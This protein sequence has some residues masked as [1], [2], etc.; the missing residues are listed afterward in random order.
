LKKELGD[1]LVSSCLITMI[2]PSED[3]SSDANPPSSSFVAGLEYAPGASVN[4]IAASNHSHWQTYTPSSE[5]PLQGDYDPEPLPPAYDRIPDIYLQHVQAD[6]RITNDDP[7]MRIFRRNVVNTSGQ[8]GAHPNTQ[9]AHEPLV[10]PSAYARPPNV[11]EMIG[12]ATSSAPLD[13]MIP[14]VHSN[15]YPPY[16][17][18]NSFSGPPLPTPSRGLL[19]SA[20]G[21]NSPGKN[22][23]PPMPPSF[24]R[25]PPPNLICTTFPPMCL[26]ANGRYLDE[27]F[28]VAPPPSLMQPHPF[29]SRDVR[30]VDWIR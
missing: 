1:L 2:L 16:S 3:K 20:G 21:A 27:G 5:S 4:R 25:P 17:S 26:I 11:T 8:A 15:V 18:P 30:E 7:P 24:S 14:S 23:T 9:T 13:H 12:N 6:P 10:E 29:S 19:S 22:Q 28:P